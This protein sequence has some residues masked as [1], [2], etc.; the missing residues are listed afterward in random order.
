MDFAKKL[1][2]MAIEAKATKINRDREIVQKV[3]EDIKNKCERLASKGMFQ[4]TFGCFLYKKETGYYFYQTG[5]DG[6]GISK[7]DCVLL[8]EMLKEEGLNV[9]FRHKDSGYSSLIISWERNQNEP[10]ML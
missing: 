9:N 2:K 6:D 3:F 1:R 4:K 10:V 5:N 8:V 7:V